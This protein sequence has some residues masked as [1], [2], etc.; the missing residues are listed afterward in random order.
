M[1]FLLYFLTR[2]FFCKKFSILLA[3]VCM[4]MKVDNYK[5]EISTCGPPSVSTICKHRAAEWFPYQFSSGYL[6]QSCQASRVV[7]LILIS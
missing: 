7:G 2:F 6:H 5:W 1:M 4:D 3:L